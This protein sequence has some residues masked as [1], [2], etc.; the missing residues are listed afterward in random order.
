VRRM[1]TREQKE[2]DW[3]GRGKEVLKRRSEES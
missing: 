3:R 2:G 1:G